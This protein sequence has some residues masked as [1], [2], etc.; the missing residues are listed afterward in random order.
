MASP[1]RRLCARRLALGSLVVLLS[2]C[3]DDPPPVAHDDTGTTATDPPPLTTAPA[4]EGTTTTVD[5][6]TTASPPT[7][8]TTTVDP[9]TTAAN[10]G[11]TTDEPDTT[12]PSPH[13]SCPAGML[14]LGMLPT[15]VVTSTAL[16]DDE[17]QGTCGGGSAPD[18][19]YTLTA[20]ADGSYV[21]DTIGSGIDTVLYVLDGGCEGPQLRCND[22]GVPGST[23]S[24]TSLPLAAGQTVTV[25]V[26]GFSVQGGPVTLS[27]H[28]GTVECPAGD[29][30]GPLP[31]TVL[32]QTLLATDQFE[33]SCGTPDEPDQAL[34]FTATQDGIYRFDTL[35]SDFDT[36]LSVLD[37]TCG[38]PELS[39]NNDEPG[40][41][42]GPSALTLPLSTGQSVTAVVEGWLGNAGNFAVSIDRLTGT[43]PDEDLGAMPVP[44]SLMGSTAAADEASAGSCGG[45][46]SPDHAYLWTAPA[47]GAYRFDTG[48]SV[49]DTVVYLLDG[50]CL[51]PELACND[52]AG[53]PTATAAA[54]LLAGQTVVIVI[55]GM[56][57]AQGSFS[58]LVEETTDS[59]DCCVP[60]PTPGC[61]DVPLQICVCTMDAF[62]CT[63]EW[64]AIC[65]DLGLA[66][67]GAICL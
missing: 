60:H 2:G 67:C 10:P 55:D 42:G 11:T 34:T 39:C 3:F 9:D 59:G 64:D 28:E 54:Y 56:G 65:V 52:D 41:F 44:F 18:I 30:G 20:P 33:P 23:A 43:C 51:G 46:G 24:L 38:G 27:V 5:P 6:D 40:T 35:G 26:D 4:S 61:Q 1:P 21:I 22:D 14:D 66:S 53:G 31:Q 57:G 62:C 32:G 25:V 37:G 15:T 49:F 36:V 17:L 8:D 63:N 7:D 50:G 48:G 45:L 12:G 13:V 16:Q 19:A 29:L 58:L 47:D